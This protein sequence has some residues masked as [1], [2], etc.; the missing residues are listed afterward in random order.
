MPGVPQISVLHLHNLL[1][2]KPHTLK[3]NLQRKNMIFFQ[4][5]R[6]LSTLSAQQK[7]PFDKCL[8]EELR[9]CLKNREIFGIPGVLQ[10]SGVH[11]HMLHFEK[12]TEITEERSI[13]TQTAPCVLQINIWHTQTRTRMIAW[14]PIWMITS[15]PRQKVCRKWQMF[16]KFMYKSNFLF[17]SSPCK[18]KE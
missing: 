18:A 15:A 17:L 9:N 8:D 12:N 6:N 11:P 4:P 5:S 2:F 14:V 10:I 16:E 3:I 1:I 7:I 13:M